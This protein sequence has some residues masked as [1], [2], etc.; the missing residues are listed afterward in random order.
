M[1]KLIVKRG[2]IVVKKLS[3]PQAV[4]AFTVGCEHGNDIII[5]DDDISFFHLQFEKQNGDYYVRDLQSQWGTFVNNEK[6]STR[7]PVQNLDEVRLGR[8]SIIFIDPDAQPQEAKDHVLTHEPAP[9][10]VPAGPMAPKL[11]EQILGVPALRQLN[12]WVNTEEDIDVRPARNIDT[13]STAANGFSSTR[14]A[15]P[16][17]SKNSEPEPELFFN[18]SEKAKFNGHNPETLINLSKPPSPDDANMQTSGETEAIENIYPESQPKTPIPASSPPSAFA[19]KK[20]ASSS[21][22]AAQVQ[23]KPVSSY[24]LLGIYGYYLGRKFKIKAPETRI[25]RD[26]KFN[27]IVI[28]KNSKGQLDQSVSRRH[29]TLKFKNGKWLV[30]DKRS[31]TRTRINKRKLEVHDQVSISPDNELEIISDKKSHIF[32]MVEDGDWDY[33]FPRKAGPWHVRNIMRL[34][35]AGAAIIVV[36]AVSVFI[37]SFITRHRIAGQPDTLAIDSTVWGSSDVDSQFAVEGN[38]LTTIFPA[39]TDVN[40]DDHIDLI[41]INNR[42]QLT[43]TDGKTKVPLWTKTDTRFL[44]GMPVMLADLF[45]K[46]TDDIVV[47]SDDSRIRTIDGSSGLEIWKSPILPGP[48]TSHPIVADVNG[49]GLKDVAVAGADNAIYIGFGTARD[50]RWSKLSTN[51]ELRSGL[52]AGDVT[53]DGIANILAGTEDGR[54]VIADGRDQ[55][56]VGYINVDEELNKATGSFNQKNR[57]RSP[58]AIADLNSDG[59]DDMVVTTT[60]GNLLVLAG[61]NLNRLWYNISQSKQIQMPGTTLGDLD[62]DDLPDIIVQGHDGKLRA[63]KGMG[64]GKDRKMILWEFP[65]KSR[66]EFTVSPI[67]A[68]FNKNGTMDVFAIGKQSGIRILEGATGKTLF[69][70][71]LRG[72]LVLSQPVVAD[73]DSDNTV[74]I[75][76]LKNN[77]RFHKLSTNRTSLSSVVLWGQAFADSRHTSFMNSEQSNTKTYTIA[78]LLS[79]LS[80]ACIAGIQIMLRRSRSKLSYY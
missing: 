8:H 67:L 66:D 19:E 34:L 49:D 63:M 75:L 16:L 28:R 21:F 15:D 48:L 17:H 30:S 13:A 11:E 32:R 46:G 27:D 22:Q 6:I 55:R 61:G 78:M 69:K 35:N 44:A 74:D 65:E 79:L 4:E 59:I 62:G 68:D 58:V 1:P 47:V 3:V 54:V 71:D 31:K 52:S 37:N 56:V 38:N 73:F 43:C 36:L 7:T 23:Q 26:G 24:Y 57:I 76:L 45:N 20:N 70:Q 5:K 10:P 25:G 29:A 33:S 14:I 60:Q 18:K 80:I 72:E 64:Q 50:F 9:R 51:A 53:G 39:A 12:H 2:E 77:G 41:Y 40:R 42:G